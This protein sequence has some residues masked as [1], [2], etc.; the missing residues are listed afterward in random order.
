M[1]TLEKIQRTGRLINLL[2][3]IMGVILIIQ[4]VIGVV[5][6]IILCLNLN[7]FN[8]FFVAINDNYLFEMLERFGALSSIPQNYV[9][10][11]QAFTSSIVHVFMLLIL[12]HFQS[13][14]SSLSESGKPFRTETARYMRKDL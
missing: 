13:F 9:Y 1:N 6:S 8:E 10:A 4:A 3:T 5:G 11:I 14:I 7:F 12:R 2:C